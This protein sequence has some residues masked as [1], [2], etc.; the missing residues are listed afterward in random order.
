MFSGNFLVIWPFLNV[1]QTFGDKQKFLQKTVIDKRLERSRKSWLRIKERE[2]VGRFETF[3]SSGFGNRSASAS[4]C[5]G[6]ICTENAPLRQRPNRGMAHAF[7]RTF[8]ICLR[9]GWRVE[10]RCRRSTWDIWLSNMYMQIYMNIWSDRSQNP[11]RFKPSSPERKAQTINA[12]STDAHLFAK[13][14]SGRFK[15][16][17]NSH[18]DQ[19]GL[20][21]RLRKKYTSHTPATQKSNNQ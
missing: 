7:G 1:S 21:P 5:Y 2:P 12:K 18:R 10:R 20:I 15:N 13:S 4:P 3:H 14:I 11:R 17:E 9:G 8:L 19:P 6:R 16:R